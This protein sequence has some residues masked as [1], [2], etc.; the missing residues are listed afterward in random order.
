[1][2]KDQGLRILMETS[3][4]VTGGVDRP[5]ESHHAGPFSYLLYWI[6]GQK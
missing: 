4:G 3:Q 2:K 5:G 6:K 1:M